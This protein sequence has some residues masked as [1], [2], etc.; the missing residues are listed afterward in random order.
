[1]EVPVEEPQPEPPALETI[2]EKL[3]DPPK[4]AAQVQ[5]PVPESTLSKVDPS[6]Q[7]IASSL[8]TS[9][10][11]SSAAATPSP[12]LA[13]RSA[14]ASSRASARNR[15]TDQ[16]VVMPSSFGSGVEK[17]GMQFGSLSLNGES[18][19]ETTPYVHLFV[20]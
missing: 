19:F 1:M 18:L 17:V 5:A 12:K 13:S 16:P 9:A 2:V 3:E 8:S 10:L 7:S 14:V 4:P 11:A 15:T 20:C 6:P